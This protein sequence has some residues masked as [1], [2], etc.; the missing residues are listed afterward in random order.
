MPLDIN[1]AQQSI[2][3]KID[4]YK[5]YREVSQSEKG[6]L[7]KLGNSSSEANSKISS[8]L[9][10]VSEFQKDFKE[11]LLIQWTNYWDFWDKHKGMVVQH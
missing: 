10:K 11:S 7:G 8:Q 5:T 6:L 3:S 9:N 2:Q 1:S 4:A